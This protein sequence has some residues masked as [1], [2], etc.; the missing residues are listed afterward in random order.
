MENKMTQATI[1]FLITKVNG[2][3]QIFLFFFENFFHK[4]FK[5]LNKF[6]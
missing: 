6:K 5:Q 3:K 2:I 1:E 4:K